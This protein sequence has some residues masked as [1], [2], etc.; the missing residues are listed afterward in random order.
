MFYNLIYKR[1]ISLLIIF[2]IAGI[3]I[4]L[5]HTYHISYRLIRE[6]ALQSTLIYSKTLE[7]FRTIYTSEVTERIRESGVPIIHDYLTKN[8]AIPLPVT[9]TLKLAKRLANIEPGMKVRL[10]SE[11]PF[12]WRRLEGNISLDEFEQNA[13]IELKKNAESTYYRFENYNGR[14]SLRYATADKMRADCIKC[15]NGH[16]QSPKNDWKIG[17]VRGV[18]EIIRPLD[19]I[20][21]QVKNELEG[22]GILLITTSSLLLMALVLVITKFRQDSEK[23]SVAVQQ[24][25]EFISIASHELKS[26]LSSLILQGQ[27]LKHVVDH[28]IIVPSSKEKIII[29]LKKIENQIKNYTAL[30]NNLLDSTHISVGKLTLH[31][32]LINLSELVK[33]TVDQLRS[34]FIREGYEIKEN[35]NPSI[36]GE[37][38][39]SR[40]EQVVINLL[41]NA[42]KY[43]AKKPIEISVYTVGNQAI[44]KISDHGI[45]ISKADQSIIFEKFKRVTHSEKSISGL[46]LGLYITRQIVLAHG[47]NIRVESWPGKGSIFTV[48]LLLKHN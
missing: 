4:T 39:R 3:F 9:L 33:N 44:I 16:P 45:G 30:I 46:G 18:L 28:E 38:D 31:L 20:I 22:T 6:S 43:G 15:H 13:L 37:W 8:G 24:R 47:G 42:I 27:M 12:P 11:F 35:I 19:P 5:W 48:E 26:P 32:E 34:D 10:Y 29:L 36:M 17:D 14:P 23:L 7:E 25:D 1:T 21:I 2:L 41:S 40:I